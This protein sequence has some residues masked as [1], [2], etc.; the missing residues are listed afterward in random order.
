MLVCI[1]KKIKM[2]LYFFYCILRFQLTDIVPI[3]KYIYIKM[4]YTFNVNGLVTKAEFTH[5]QSIKKN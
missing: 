2:L 3:S 1:F 5:D 4:L